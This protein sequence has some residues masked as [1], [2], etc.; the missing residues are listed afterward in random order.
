MWKVYNERINYN[1]F[2]GVYTTRVSG[3]E[4]GKKEVSGAEESVPEE[5]TFKETEVI[6]G[7]VI[8]GSWGS[9]KGRGQLPK[10]FYCHHFTKTL[11]VR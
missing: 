2:V 11:V 4:S 6:W 10:E 8:A 5:M 3:M 9:K 1:R 7:E